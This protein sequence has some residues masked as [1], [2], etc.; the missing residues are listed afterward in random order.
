MLCS[1][2]S[3]RQVPFV[4]LH[5]GDRVIP[6]AEIPQTS[7]EASVYLTGIDWLTNLT[8]ASWSIFS[9]FHKPFKNLCST[10]I[11]SCDVWNAFEIEIFHIIKIF[12]KQA[13]RIRYYTYLFLKDCAS[14][15]IATVTDI[16]T[17]L[18]LPIDI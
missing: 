8:L 3:C 7:T 2:L 1:I 6:T 11:L 15:L 17:H 12:S 4:L 5:K 13:I 18:S 9:L 10:V 16:I 14:I